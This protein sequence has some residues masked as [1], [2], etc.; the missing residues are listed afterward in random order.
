MTSKNREVRRI[1]RLMDCLAH[2]NQTPALSKPIEQM[3]YALLCNV[4]SASRP[5]H[6]SLGPFLRSQML[7]RSF[8][9]E[10]PRL[11]RLS[12][13]SLLELLLAQHGLLS[14]VLVDMGKP[15]LPMLCSLMT[16]S[17]NTLAMP[18]T[19][20]PANPFLQL[21]HSYLSLERHSVS[22]MVLHMLFGFVFIQH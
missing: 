20:L 10:T 9:D 16:T 2:P 22:S 19:L 3:P 13:W 21:M 11:L 15:C 8:S 18:I 7:P 1:L 14:W 5:D 17:E 12:T 6:F 4:R